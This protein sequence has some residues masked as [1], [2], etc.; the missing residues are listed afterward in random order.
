VGFKLCMGRPEEFMAIIH[1]MVEM[2]VTPDF[3]TIDGGEGG[4]GAAPP[5]FSNSV[6]TPL[7]DGLGLVNNALIGAGL[8]DEVRIIAS[9]RVLS[10]MSVVRNLALGADTVNAARAMM[11]AL[12]CIQAL[13]CNTNKCPTGIATQDQ[14]LMGGLHVQSKMFRVKEYHRNTVHAAIELC[15]AAGLNSPGELRPDHIMKRISPTR[16]H[17]MAELYPR[18]APGC[19]L[20]GQAKACA[21][22]GG[23]PLV[24]AQQW[25]A[26]FDQYWNMGKVELD[27]F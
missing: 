15:E 1:A 9:G 12:G 27:R 16:A 23:V 18:L 3:I 11:F 17:S 4:T 10:G 20:Q 7:I 6:G 21:E 22:M 25:E 26:R 14:R 8:R 2:Q 5:E 19:L 24:E 13:Q